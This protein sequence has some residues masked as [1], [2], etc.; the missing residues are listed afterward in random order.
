MIFQNTQACESQLAGRACVMTT[1]TG[2][3]NMPGLN[4]MQT[5]VG[6]CS[7]RRSSSLWLSIA[8]CRHSNS[9]VQMCVGW[10]RCCGRPLG[11]GSALCLLLM[12]SSLLLTTPCN[13]LLL[14]A[15]WL[16]PACWSLSQGC[17]GMGSGKPAQRQ[18]TQ[19]CTQP[20]EISAVQRCPSRI[21]WEA[22]PGPSC[23]KQQRGSA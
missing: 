7:V 9:S 5:M 12:L 13:S 8:T 6:L 23:P 21:W 3:P 15:Q 20:A 2:A 18:S 10:K 1:L 16:L 22:G 14:P 17:M 4:V 19:G 11:K